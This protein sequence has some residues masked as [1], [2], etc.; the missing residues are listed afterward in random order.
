[1]Q[2][3]HGHLAWSLCADQPPR[4]R[5][6]TRREPVRT[7]DFSVPRPDG[8]SRGIAQPTVL[9]SERS[10]AA[11]IGQPHAN[12][13]VPVGDGEKVCQSDAVAEIWLIG[14]RPRSA[15]APTG[16]DDLI[17]Q[18]DADFDEAV[19]R[20]LSKNRELYRRLA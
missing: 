16:P 12:Q 15:V 20:V 6:E 2:I 13:V 9:A 11:V 3:R 5:G 1:M 18:P 4:Q 17:G 8:T 14:H 19:R 10:D 7:F